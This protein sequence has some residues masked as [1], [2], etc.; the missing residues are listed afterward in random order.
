M[1]DTSKDYRLLV[2]EKSV[3]LFMRAVEGA[4]FKGK[5]NNSKFLYLL[6]NPL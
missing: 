2:A 5:W 1:W 4:N 6:H 3:E